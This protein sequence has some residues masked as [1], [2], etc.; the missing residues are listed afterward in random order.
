MSRVLET[1]APYARALRYS[2]RLRRARADAARPFPGDG[3]PL[4]TP[5]AFVM[6]C[7]RSGTTIVGEVFASHPEVCYLF[8]PYHL[9]AAVDPA[10][11]MVNLYVEGDALCL[12]DW[13]RA[14]P[15]ACLRFRRAMHAAQARSGRPRIVEKTPINALRLG[16]LEALAP[17]AAYV[18]MVRDG[19]DTARSIERLAL[20]VRPRIAGRPNWNPWWGQAGCKWRFLARDGAAAGYFAHEVGLLTSQAQRGAYEWLVSQSEVERH[21]PRLG[22]RLLDVPYAH[23]T[24]SPREVLPRLCTFLGIDPDP[25]GDW[26]GRASTMVRPEKR[27]SG[28]PLTLPPHMCAAFNAYQERLGFEARAAPLARAGGGAS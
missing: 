28:E 22:E 25:P 1:V 10:A 6:G 15:D 26:L 8:E 4:G 21:R 11:D 12:M 24:A 19:V 9:W 14:T 16:F 17:G 27:S 20:K 23:L 5:P 2:L 7:G 3:A 18:H 13:R